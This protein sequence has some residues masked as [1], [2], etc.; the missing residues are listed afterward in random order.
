MDT[1]FS[2]I[3]IPYSL[4]A[5]ANVPLL[6][7]ITMNWVFFVSLCR[8]FAY[9][10]TLL[11]SSA[12]SISSSKQNGDG[13][14]FC[15]ANKRHIAVSAFSPPDNCI[16]FCSFFPG[17]C[18]MMVMA[19]SSISASGSSSIVPFPPPKSCLNT[20][21]NSILI[22]SNLVVNC[23]RIFLSSSSITV[24]S[25]SLADTR[26]SCWFFKNS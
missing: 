7:V 15:I 18:E 1:P 10:S 5:A 16:I 4:S 22:S 17:G 14:R 13:L 26:S 20:L 25:L 19:A 6:W 23:S 24:I 12:A 21:S 2:C 11:S 9:L 3:V 8:Y